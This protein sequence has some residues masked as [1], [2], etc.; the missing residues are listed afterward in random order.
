[1]AQLVREF[2]WAKTPVGPVAAWP[3]ELKTMVGF[4]LGSRFP[5]A[6]V[7]GK[8]LT[9]IYNDAFLPILGDKPEALGRPFS[10][11]W[12]EVWDEVE[13]IARRALAGESTF[14]ED[15]PLVINRSGQPEQVSFTFC[16]SPLR[17]AD[18]TICGL[19]DTVIETTETVQARADLDTVAQEMGHRLKNTMATVQALAS[20]SLKGVAER[21]AVEAFLDRVVTLGHAHD[22]LFRENW[23]V[24]ALRHVVEAT[25]SPLN[26]LDQI[27]L[28]GPHVRIGARLTMALSL[29]LHELATNAAKYGALSVPE[30]RVDL[31]WEIDGD[32]LRMHWRESGGPPV[33]PPAHSG[34][35]SRLIDLG[36]APHGVVDRRYPPT[37]AEV[38]LAAPV[39]G[40]LDR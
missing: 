31:A 19:M 16:Y 5:A 27:R 22:V 35:G 23:S 28:S 10:E 9:T 34:F 2:D 6:I 37:G 20:Q 39:S 26:G 30:G 1:M 24:V 32:Q 4:I 8:A 17:L 38:D 33:E 13:P 18:G 25:L 29:V 3:P 11:V 21:G 15:F 12:A 36:L 7:W 14:I 40:L